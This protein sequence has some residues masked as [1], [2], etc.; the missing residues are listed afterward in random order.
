MR[1]TPHLITALAIDFSSALRAYTPVKHINRSEEWTNH[2][3]ALAA[4]VNVLFTRDVKVVLI[5]SIER[6]RANRSVGTLQSTQPLGNS[7]L[8]LDFC[9][10]FAYA[11]PRRVL[12]RELDFL[13]RP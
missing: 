1:P 11:V 9:F 6:C 3:V 5:W 12:S 10:G 4:I 7:F 13:N 2:G 8:R